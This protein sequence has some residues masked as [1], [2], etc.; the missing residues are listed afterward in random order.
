MYSKP[1]KVASQNKILEN[2]SSK[3]K[4]RK[5]DNQKTKTQTDKRTDISTIL[6]LVSHANVL[7]SGLGSQSFFTDMM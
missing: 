2:H 3:T 4:G 5:T 6:V 7:N 1:R